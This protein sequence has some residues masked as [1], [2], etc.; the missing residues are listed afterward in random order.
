MFKHRRLMV[1]AG[2]AIG[3]SGVSVR[4]FDRSAADQAPPQASSA[5]APGTPAPGHRLL[6]DRAANDMGGIHGTVSADGQW[7]SFPHWLSC[8]LGVRNLVTGESRLVTKYGHCAKSQGKTEHAATS[9]DGRL[10]AFTWERWDPGA[11]KEGPYQVRV[12]SAD[13]QGEHAVVNNT[14]A[15]RLVEPWSWSPDSRWLAVTAFDKNGPG[16]S[17][18]VVSADGSQSRVALKLPDRTPSGVWFSPDGKW[19]AYQ[20][21]HDASPQMPPMVARDTRQQSVYV[22]SA[23]QANS[24]PVQIV[25]DAGIMGWTP[26]ASALLFR[27]ERNTLME[28]YVQP[29]SNGRAAGVAW[30]VPGV[31]DVGHPMGV[32]AQGTLV[33]GTLRQTADAIVT[34]VDPSSGVAGPAAVMM[35]LARVGP[36]GMGGAVRF[37]PDGKQVLYAS[38]ANTML[39]RSL[40][41]GTERTFT[42]QMTKLDWIEWAA[43][44]GSL[45]ISGAAAGRPGV[46]RVD[47]RNGAVTLLF[48]APA[49]WPMLPSLDG[50]LLYYVKRGA[51]AVL[52]A[53]DL[54]TGAERTVTTHGEGLSD[55]NLSRDGGTLALMGSKILSLMN[56]Q[57]GAAPVRF[58]HEEWAYDRFESGEFSADGRH[59]LAYVSFSLG[60]LGK[61]ELWSL[62]VAGGPPIRQSVSW[63]MRG[64][65][66]SRDGTQL[67]SIRL[68]APQQV[69]AVDGFL[70]PAKGTR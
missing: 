6:W 40:V 26:D 46:Y 35:P 67:G 45:F 70:K 39:L 38:T 17:I 47:L 31:T 55:L 21:S 5:T 63:P 68:E 51:A 58:R 8:G 10:I 1:V 3:V 49:V 28:L 29:V 48:E 53:R 32:T 44:S 57:T 52:M 65:S 34:S 42:P 18:L 33:Y 54:G 4:G 27:R 36:N 24:A 30:R 62:P 66:L 7:L 25:A 64:L 22:I 12:I 37:A 56:L 14:M 60:R 41:D 43:D 50:H 61:T 15:Y 19:L 59:F 13:G 9:P 23:D 69:W 11:E 16:G 2:L 20:A